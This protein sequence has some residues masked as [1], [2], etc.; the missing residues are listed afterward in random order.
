MA[1]FLP[2]GRVTAPSVC[3]RSITETLILEHESLLGK[4]QGPPAAAERSASPSARS[5]T[6]AA[7]APTAAKGTPVQGAASGRPGT[8][9]LSSA[10]PLSTTASSS[11]APA[12]A[13]G[14][15]A[16][17]D[18]AGSAQSQFSVY[19][20]AGLSSGASAGS[21]PLASQAAGAQGPIRGPLSNFTNTIQRHGSGAPPGGQQKPL[22]PTFSGKKSTA[23]L[24]GCGAPLS[25]KLGA[26]LRLDEKAAVIARLGDSVA[27]TTATLFMPLDGTLVEVRSWIW[28]EGA[29][30]P[31]SKSQQHAA[32]L[33]QK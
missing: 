10:G 11:P 16:A 6:T 12:R 9:V 1:L 30:P 15:P 4:P 2:G 27:A 28:R 8:P 25:P 13:A 17:R 33:Q 3:A 18:D 26:G 20:A 14:A 19:A 21:G 29:F 24:S 7:P 5:S 22:S 31:L 23:S 32:M